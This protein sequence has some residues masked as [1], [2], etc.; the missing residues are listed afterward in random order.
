MATSIPA[1]LSG[2]YRNICDETNSADL[3][4]PVNTILRPIAATAGVRAIEVDCAVQ[5]VACKTSSVCRGPATCEL[6]SHSSS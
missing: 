4:E 2:V 1:D 6:L 5:D 3:M